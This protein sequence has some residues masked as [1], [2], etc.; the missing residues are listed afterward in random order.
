[1]PGNL[2]FAIAA[3]VAVA[4][5]LV[6]I[7]YCVTPQ[8]RRAKKPFRAFSAA[9]LL[10]FALIYSLAACDVRLFHIGAGI[11]SA[12][13]LSLLACLLAAEAI[14]DWGRK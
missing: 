4:A 7:A 12:I 1:M 6:N 8:R 2:H 14:A 9:A 3:F 5:A 13:G 10:F 11:H